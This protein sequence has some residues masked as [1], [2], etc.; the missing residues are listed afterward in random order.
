MTQP[1][2]AASPQNDLDEAFWRHCALRRLCFQRCDDCGA[3]RHL[4]RHACARCGSPRW[5]WRE[6]SGRGRLFTWTV[7]H[8]PPHPSLAAAVPYVSAIVELEEGVRIVST[9]DGVPAAALRVDLALALDWLAL[10]DGTLLPIFRPRP[11]A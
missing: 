2:V 9:T 5:S 8:R 7:T 11:E 3:W 10:G 4:P 1:W 6:S